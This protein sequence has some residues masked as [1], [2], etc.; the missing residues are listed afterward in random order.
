MKTFPIHKLRAVNARMDA[1]IFHNPHIGLEPT[2]FYNINISIEPFRLEQDALDVE[3]ENEVDSCF[4]LEFIKLNVKDWRKLDGQ[5][6]YLTPDDIDGSFYVSYAHNPVDIQQI[7][8]RKKSE[9]CFIVDCVLFIDFEFEGSGYQN[10]TVVFR[11]LPLLFEGLRI[12]VKFVNLPE[13]DSETAQAFAK[14]FVDL[15]A[16]H[17]PSLNTKIHFDPIRF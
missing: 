11:D 17:T 10:T 15:E 1:N 2:L 4:S 5:T 6:F 8:F 14:D 9:N 16:F 13:W 7:T 12:D 3:F